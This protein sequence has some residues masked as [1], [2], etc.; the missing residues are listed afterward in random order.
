[1]PMITCKEATQLANYWTVVGNDA[2]S[3]GDY[4]TAAYAYGKAS[5]YVELWC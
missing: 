1:M 3:V 2:Y 4:G 5:R